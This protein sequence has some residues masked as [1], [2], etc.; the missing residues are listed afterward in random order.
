MTTPHSYENAVTLQECRELSEGILKATSELVSRDTPVHVMLVAMVDALN[1][2]I[3]ALPAEDREMA[4]EQ[5]L[6][7]I[8]LGLVA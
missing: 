6:R 2:L 7:Y 1:H 8:R 3:A 5:M 4:R